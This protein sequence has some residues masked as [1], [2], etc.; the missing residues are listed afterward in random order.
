MLQE[1]GPY[2]EFCGPTWPL[3][4]AAASSRAG[5]NSEKKGGACLPRR[6]MSQKTGAAANV[7]TPP[8]AELASTADSACS[9]EA[10]AKTPSPE[11]LILASV[12][13]SLAM[14]AVQYAMLASLHACSTTG[15]ACRSF[16]AG[17]I[18]L[19]G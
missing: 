3:G 6:R 16:F 11:R 10:G 15:L 14:P 17:H 12:A 7:L 2:R 5:A 4:L 1:Q 8:P 13:E 19:S 9:P 18:T